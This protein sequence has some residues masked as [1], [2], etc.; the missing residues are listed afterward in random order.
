M[1]VSPIEPIYHRLQKHL[2]A[3]DT[4]ILLCCRKAKQDIFLYI[5]YSEICNQFKDSKRWFKQGLTLGVRKIRRI[6]QQEK[7]F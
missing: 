7:P 1:T 6:I 4:Q 3:I 5:D 2:L